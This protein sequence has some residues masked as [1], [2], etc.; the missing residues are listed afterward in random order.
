MQSLCIR[1]EIPDRFYG[2]TYN[3]V[4][5]PCDS[6]Q[7]DFSLGANCQVFA[8]ALLKHFGL[9]VP[10]FRSSELW[11]DVTWTRSTTLF[12]PLDLMLYNQNSDAFGAH[13]GV[14]VGEGEVFHL[15]LGNG[16]PKFELHSDLLKQDKYRCFIGAK[17]VINNN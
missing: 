9:S 10:N 14:F 13:V 16:T 3:S 6:W 15:S 5:V 8:Y 1:T 4:V 17:R 11:D 12:C 2:V 7:G